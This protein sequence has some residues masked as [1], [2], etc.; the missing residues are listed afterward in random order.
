M[1]ND[2]SFDLR[3][4]IALLSYTCKGNPAQAIMYIEMVGKTHPEM[5]AEF[6]KLIVDGTIDLTKADLME[7]PYGRIAR[8]IFSEGDVK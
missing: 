1:H 7:G 5:C 8:T 2:D 6:S 3:Y 4:A